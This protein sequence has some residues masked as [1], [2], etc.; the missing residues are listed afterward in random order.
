MDAILSSLATLLV[1]GP[2]YPRPDVPGPLLDI[3]DV[4][5]AETERAGGVFV[6]PLAE[7]WFWDGPPEL[8]GGDE[9]H[10]TDAGHVYLA[11]HIEPHIKQ[12]L[13][14]G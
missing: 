6:D 3:R 1:I 12:A 2:A 5:K 8:I 4:L 7:G 13:G 10:P 11:Q 14:I 9:V